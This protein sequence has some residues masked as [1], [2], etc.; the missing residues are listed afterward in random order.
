MK[1]IVDA[2]P[3]DA[4]AVLAKMIEEIPTFARRPDRPGWGWGWDHRINGAK[5]FIRQTKTGLSAMKIRDNG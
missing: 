5:Y 3:D 2:D 1:F 4:P